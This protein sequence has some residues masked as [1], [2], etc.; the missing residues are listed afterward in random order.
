MV[1]IFQWYTVI[2]ASAVECVGVEVGETS[3]Y[4]VGT[5]CSEGKPV[6]SVRSFMAEEKDTLLS[7]IGSN[8]EAPGDG[9]GSKSA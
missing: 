1:A 2:H 8:E 9:K 4:R 7:M 3:L 6:D 5:R